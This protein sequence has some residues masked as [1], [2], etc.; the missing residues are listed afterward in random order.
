LLHQG[1]AR[2]DSEEIRRS[3][4]PVPD[5]SDPSSLSINWNS[6]SIPRKG[7]LVLDAEVIKVPVSRDGVITG[8]YVNA[9]GLE[10][11]ILSYDVHNF[12]R[13]KVELDP[14]WRLGQPDELEFLAIGKNYFGSLVFAI[15]IETG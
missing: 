4:Q 7:I 2:E 12:V 8:S 15:L 5:P 13:V 11:P 3:A 1:G 14:D 10:L 6:L 9:E